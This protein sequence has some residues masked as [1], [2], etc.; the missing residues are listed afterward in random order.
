MP[1]AI[2]LHDRWLQR[3][4]GNAGERLGRVRDRVLD[5]ARLQRHHV[6][7]DLSAGSGLLTWEIL[8]RAPEGGTWAL[9]QSREAGEGL[10]QQA[11]RLPELRRPVVLVGEMEELPELFA[12]RG[13][14]ELRFDAI[15]GRNVLGALACKES[16]LQLA[17]GL[18]RPGGRVSLVETVVRGA[19]RLYELVDLSLLSSDLQA[20]IV[21]AEE[22]IYAAEDD[23]LVNWGEQDL[24]RILR[25]AAGLDEVSVEIEAQTT[26]TLIGPAAI[27]R[28]FSTAQEGK[29]LSYAQ[30]LLR[31]VTPDEL[32]E[33]QALFQRQLAGQTVPWHSMLAFA[34]G[35]AHA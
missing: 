31:R 4:I 8:R 12:L 3:T 34:G 5:A 29:R 19:Q 7:L 33:V 2:A 16:A 6:V 15:V 18:L 26:E 22:Q 13:E 25:A 21:E 20:R 32:A 30:Q 14:A 1:W 27:E 23:P 9:A 35:C 10:R 11:E 28:W 24:E 17:A